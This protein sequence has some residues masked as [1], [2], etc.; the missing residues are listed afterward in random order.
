M[1][2]ALSHKPHKL[3]QVAFH[4]PE[5]KE[6]LTS[7]L[8]SDQVFINSALAMAPSKKQVANAYRAANALGIHKEDIKP[9]LQD[10]YKA[11]DKNWEH[12]EADNYR[13]LIDTYFD[14]K[15]NKVVPL[16]YFL[17]FL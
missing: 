17:F 3:L 2:C 5:Q 6:Q 10:L 7:K 13:V 8:V 16:D 1:L 12:I 15:E 4:A 11:F 9:V 14:L